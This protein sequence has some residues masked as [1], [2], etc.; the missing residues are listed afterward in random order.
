MKIIENTDDA[1]QEIRDATRDP[2]ARRHQNCSGKAA[3]FVPRE[4]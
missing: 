2:L 1:C 3:Q 4:L